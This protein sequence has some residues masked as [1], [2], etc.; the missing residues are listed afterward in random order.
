VRA[1]A[2]HLTG[3]GRPEPQARRP[4]AAA[5]DGLT[6]EIRDLFHQGQAPGVRQQQ[7]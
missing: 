2:R 4:A 3:L 1:P 7:A 5:T 6:N